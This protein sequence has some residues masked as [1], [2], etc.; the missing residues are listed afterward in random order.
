MVF[1]NPGIY[2]DPREPIPP[3]IRRQLE[4]EREIARAQRRRPRDILR[5]VDNDRPAREPRVAVHEVGA[6]RERVMP[7]EP[8][9]HPRVPVDEAM[10]VTADEG[11]LPPISASVTA[12]LI[13]D[14]AKV[15]ITQLFSNE[16][17]SVTP[18][19][20]YTFPLPHGCTVTDF[21]CRIGRDKILT[22]KIKPKQEARDTFDDAV[23]RN[24]TAALL[25]QNN[26]EIF[27]TLLGNI[28]ARARLKVEI[29]FIYLLQYKFEQGH[30]LT[31]FTLPTY[32]APR[33][34]TPPPSL[35]EALGE[36][37]GIRS[38]K[39]ELDVLAPETISSITC[40]THPI[41]VEMGASGR[42]CQTWQ[43]F[44]Q[45]GQRED[46]KSALVHV[47]ETITHLDR[48]FVLEIQS[49]PESGLEVPQAC[50]E[51]HPE[52]ENHRALMLTIPPNFMLGSGANVGNNNNDIVF[53]A[54]R[55]GSMS[56]KVGAL[57][58]AMQFFLKGIPT[59]RRFNIWCFG[60]TFECL[61]PQ[62][63]E[64]SQ[65]NL[66]Q[67]L[68]YVEHSFHANM[69]GTKLLPALK[70]AVAA[71][72]SHRTMDIIALTDGA[73]WDLNETLDFVETTRDTTEGEVRFFC[74]G[75]GAAVS[76]A[77]VEGIA[78]LGGG[79][80]EVI[81]LA[82]ERGW[83][84]RIVAVLKAALT[85]HIGVIEVELDDQRE[86]FRTA[87]NLPRGKPFP[88]LVNFLNR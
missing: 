23:G 52:L 26:P 20:S 11:Y 87:E 9:V 13:Q 29:S 65:H 7:G 71:R 50:V 73:V 74:L 60:D 69:G 14:T 30:G 46:P 12:Q 32:I 88:T 18:K 47:R 77:L 66:H 44:V 36:S 76:H 16:S 86:I 6:P 80:A 33:F 37:T 84:S 38:L 64:Y 1:N 51:I 83:E 62:S 42:R 55:S 45:S 40:D 67:A 2:W 25:D 48:D 27:T 49:I 85:N 24:E 8:P 70:A 43:E 35:W 10:Q 17:D 5:P 56:D 28:P 31:T 19:A 54:D 63:M 61:W 78:K 21:V 79:Y 81:P 82:S 72:R 41:E 58:S 59:E 15:S 75:I 34:G 4:L 22:G 3:F 68:E 53:V 39:I 57:K